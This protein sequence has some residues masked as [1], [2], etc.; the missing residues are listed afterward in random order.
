MV[1]TY[2][3]TPPHLQEVI[4][5]A[6][7]LAV[8]TAASSNTPSAANGATVFTIGNAESGEVYSTNCE[9]WH[10]S[11]I[12]SV[13]ALPLSPNN[14]IDSGQVI[15]FTKA[16]QNI[17]LAFRDTRTELLGGNLAPGDTVVYA[18]S[19]AARV[20]LKEDGSVTLSTKD[21]TGQNTVSF[22]IDGYGMNFFAPWGSFSFDAAGFRVATAAGA[23]MSL[24]GLNFPGLSSLSSCINLNA[25]LIS[26]VSPL[27]QLGLPNLVTGYSQVVI[28]LAPVVTSEPIPPFAT[29]AASSVYIGL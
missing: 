24:G 19:S 5:I 14:N 12:M 21:S 4:G 11:G 3:L 28:P 15:Y 2:S 26:V 29:T 22:S 16:D 17:G 7:I 25:G 18:N 10:P 20:A 6:D 1:D 9:F 13:P 23:T 27:V 8:N